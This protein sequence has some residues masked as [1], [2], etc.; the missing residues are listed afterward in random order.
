[1]ENDDLADLFGRAARRMR[2]NQIERLAPLGLTPSQSRALRMIARFDAANEPLRMSE[3]ATRLDVVPRSAT[4][5]VDGLEKAGLVRRT[6]D[7]AN[8]RAILVVPTDEGRAMRTRMI[9]ARR[10][11]AEEVFAPLSPEQRESLRALLAALD[12]PAE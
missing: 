5:L 1:M 10:A 9:E 4:G 3:L 7:P 11:A 6:H 2:R 12:D 8:R